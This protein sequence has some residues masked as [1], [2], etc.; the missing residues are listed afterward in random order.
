M[1]ERLQKVLASA[2]IASRRVAE[3][4]ITDGRVKVNGTV[5]RKLGTKVNLNDMVMVDDKRIC[6][7]TPG[8][9]LFYKPRGVVTTMNDPEKRR[10]IAD[11]VSGL[12][13]HVFPVGRLDYNTEGLL[14][15]TNDGELAQRL[16]H[17]SGEVDK[18]YRATVL[19]I[20]TD[21]ELDKLR[22]GVA[23][24]DGMTAPATVTLVECAHERNLTTFDITIHEGRNRQVRRMCDAIGHPV[25]ALKRIR[26]GNLT[27]T[28]LTR[29]KIR[30]LQLSELNKLRKLVGLESIRLPAFKHLQKPTERKN[31][32]KNIR[33]GAGGKR[34]ALKS[35][36]LQSEKERIEKLY[37]EEEARVFGR[38]S[39]RTRVKGRR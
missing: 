22:I 1:E 15:L 13:Q 14:L 3:N 21:E 24:E 38:S 5:V 17:P 20:V 12:P 31:G 18:T 11:F 37:R 30:E 29:G 2:G 19:G 39:R 33:G 32:G 34:N 9:Y 16:M 23:L 28:G 7:E 35:N 36:K 8:Y 4:Y 26:F 25:R 6:R 10:C 27:L